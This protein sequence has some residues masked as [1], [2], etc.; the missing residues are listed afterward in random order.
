MTVNFSL[1]ANPTFTAKVGFKAAGQA[2]PVP[3]LLTFKHR[4]KTVLAKFLEERGDKTDAQ[5]FFD[6]VI[7]WELEEP[8][9]LVNVTELLENHPVIALETFKVYIDE[10]VQ[11]KIKN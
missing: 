8:Y 11:G 5:M 4:T 1:K 2:E 10:L 7:A 3:V 6:M 9:N